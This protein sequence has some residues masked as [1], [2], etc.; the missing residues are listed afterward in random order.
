[1]TESVVVNGNTI[2]VLIEPIGDC[3]AVV[4]DSADKVLDSGI[5]IPD[6]IQGDKPQRGT[7]I[8]LGEGMI[9]KNNPR[10]YLQV[11]DIVLFGKYAGD[12]VK[13]SCENGEDISVKVLHLE[14]I[15]GKT[16]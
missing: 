13:M 15:L 1:M 8:A 7:V 9:D 11:G 12:D 10:D 16:L 6:S 5:I 2:I 4:P 3:V 14:S